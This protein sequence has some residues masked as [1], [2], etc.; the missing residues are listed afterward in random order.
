M[1][2]KVEPGSPNIHV[3]AIAAS[4]GGLNA[5]TRVLAP[6]TSG[7]NAAIVVLQHLD[8]HHRSL[9]SAILAKRTSM[10]V[11]EACQGDRLTAGEVLI[12]PPNK[13]ILVE[14]DGRVNLSNAALVHFVRPS[15]DLLFESVAVSF[16]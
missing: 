4:A 5:I 7:L 8:P 12:A 6:L 15:A 14:P 13:H 10:R 9:M 2:L 1:P 16:G 3:I 11:S